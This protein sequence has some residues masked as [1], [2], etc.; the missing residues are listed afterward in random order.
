LQNENLEVIFMP[1]RTKEYG[2]KLREATRNKIITAAVAL[3]AEKGLAA[4]SAKD[5]ASLAGVSVGLMYHYFKT[6]EEAFAALLEYAMCDIDDI[7]NSLASD[8]PLDSLNE[9]VSEILKSLH[10]GYEFSQW[11][12][13]LSQP[14]AKSYNSEL[15]EKIE[16]FDRQFIEQIA[17]LIKQGQKQNKFKMGEPNMLAQY[18][19]STLLGICTLQLSLREDFIVPSKETLT[20]FLLS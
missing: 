4:T 16:Y 9:L 14:L 13:I 10:A 3:F 7:K 5:I 6:K 2:E 18:F 8:C 12:A 19:L 15:R 20:A 11:M 1:G 17:I